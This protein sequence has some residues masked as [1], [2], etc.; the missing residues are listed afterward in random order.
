MHADWIPPQVRIQEAELLAKAVTTVS[1]WQLEL[2]PKLLAAYRRT[3]VPT[4]AG[5]RAPHLGAVLGAALGPRGEVVHA[6]GGGVTNEELTC[7]LEEAECY[8]LECD[9]VALL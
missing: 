1:T 3:A 9:L 8:R 2:L 6:V 4:T 7:W 5:G